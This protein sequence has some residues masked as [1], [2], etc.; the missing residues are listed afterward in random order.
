MH[1]AQR[2]LRVAPSAFSGLTPFQAG[3]LAAR[4]SDLRPSDSL[5]QLLPPDNLKGIGDAARLLAAVIQRGGHIVV[6]ADYDADGAT[7]CAIA[8]R[9]IRMFGGNVSFVVPNRFTDGYGLTAP[10]VDRAAELQPDLLLTVDNGIAAIEGVHAASTLGI[11]VLV[12]DHHLPGTEL[13]DAHAIVNPNQPGCPFHSKDLA[14]CGVMFYLLL[15]VRNLFRRNGD[16]RGTVSLQPLV[17]LLALGTVADVV[18]LDYNNRLLVRAGLDRIR[19]GHAI[20]GINQLFAVANRPTKLASSMDLGFFI[21]P[22]INAAGRMDDAGVGIHCL[23][24]DDPLQAHLLAGA[25][26]AINHDRREV[27]SDTE[28][29]ALAELAPAISQHNY[30][31][32]LAHAEWHEG[33]IGI[34][35]G[36]LKEKFGRASIVFAAG[37][38][39]GV[40]KGSGRSIAALNL[41]D[42]LDRVSKRHPGLIVRFGGHAMAAGL[43]IVADRFEQFQKAF[44]QEAR[45]LLSPSDLHIVVEHDGPLAAKE[46]TVGNAEWIAQQVWGQGFPAPSFIVHA[47]VVRQKVARK[48]NLTLDLDVGGR[49]V[50]AVWFGRAEEIDSH[51][52]LLVRLGLVEWNGTRTPQLM[53]DAVIGNPDAAPTRTQG[54]P[55]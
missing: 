26:D 55:T 14:G 48:S 22:R 4:T 19:A 16:V 40:L 3:L 8:I 28:H 12:T 41:R 50:P 17:D 24:T 37:H 15:A 49:Q 27:Q 13:P 34:V 43:S 6:V 33:V 18:R 23:L 45:A 11:P 32:A 39:E 1:L 9:G 38:E 20:P 35:A 52:D 53:V 54:A 47:K 51:A 21:G 10:I 5:A 30:T 25:L 42:C 2:Q 46:I 31:I 29:S 7:G 44:E 36:K